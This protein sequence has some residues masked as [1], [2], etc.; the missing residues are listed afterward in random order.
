MVAVQKHHRCSGDDMTHTHTHT[1]P[2]MTK[3][4]PPMVAVQ[5][6]HRCSGMTTPAGHLPSDDMT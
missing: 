6:H 4:V 3:E 2:M 5:K 1:H